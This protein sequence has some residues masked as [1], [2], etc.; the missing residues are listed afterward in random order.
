MVL[1]LWKTCSQGS[2]LHVPSSD[3]SLDEF[4]SYDLDVPTIYTRYLSG[5]M[6]IG[7]RWLLPSPPLPT[8][9]KKNTCGDPGSLL[10]VNSDTPGNPQFSN[11][12]QRST[13]SNVPQCCRLEIP[14]GSFSSWIAQTQ[15]LRPRLMRRGMTWYTRDPYNG[16]KKS[17]DIEV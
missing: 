9:R 1:A 2:A 12:V 17:R 11:G 14:A 13:I 5:I 15:L 7:A 6:P 3:L 4:V 10:Q 16:P 8:T